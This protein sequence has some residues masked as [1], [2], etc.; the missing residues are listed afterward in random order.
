MRSDEDEVHELLRH[1]D[2]PIKRVDVRDVMHRAQIRRWNAIGRAA[3]ILVM[4][5]IGGVAWAAPRAVIASW[6][7]E[8]VART[9]QRS[10][11]TPAASETTAVPVA[12]FVG[13]VSTE[14]AHVRNRGGAR[15]ETPDHLYFSAEHR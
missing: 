12:N 4:L 8:V 10:G 15:N 7:A 9:N 13:D 1:L 5:G 14:T 3:A 11:T 6:I 2:H